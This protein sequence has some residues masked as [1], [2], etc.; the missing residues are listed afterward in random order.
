MVSDAVSMLVGRGPREAKNRYILS[1]TDRQ[2][3]ATYV[4]DMVLASVD[5]KPIFH[6]RVLISCSGS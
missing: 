3:V 4:N 6:G 5:H 1:Y 2:R